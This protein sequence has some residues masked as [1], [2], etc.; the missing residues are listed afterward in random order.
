MTAISVR[1]LSHHT[2]R[3]L[4]LV[5]AGESVEITERGK[6]IARIVPVD[7]EHDVR[8]RL[9]AEGTRHPATRGRTALLTDVL[10]RLNRETVDV[11]NRASTA[12]LTSRADER[13]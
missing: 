3:C 11:E 6:V 8:A 7:A 12:L 10:R 5:K 1:D 13:H 4:A 9:L 2:A